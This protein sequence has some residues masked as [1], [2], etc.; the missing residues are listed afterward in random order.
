MTAMTWE[1]RR[2]ALSSDAVR[3]DVAV[4]LDASTR[5]ALAAIGVAFDQGRHAVVSR[6]GREV[7]ADAPVADLADG[8]LLTVV[9]LTA[10]SPRPSAKTV[11]MEQART[12]HHAVWWLLATTAVMLAAAALGDLA[13]S[14]T[15]LGDSTRI[16]VAAALG[17]GAAIAAAWWTLRASTTGGTGFALTATSSLAF[18]AGVVGAPHMEGATHLA[19][20]VGLLCATVL[21]ALMA[22]A[23]SER[24]VR[25]AIAAATAVF[26]VLAIVWGGTLLLQWA[27]TTAAAISLGLVAPCIRWIPNLLLDFEDGYAI[28]FENFMSSRWSVRGAVPA[29]P[30]QV[31][32][33]VVKP[34]VDESLAK[35][36]TGILMLSV[37]AAIT[38]PL[39][40]PGI[41]ASN[42]LVRIGTI[43]VIAATIAALF[44]SPRHSSSTAL[45]WMPRVTSAFMAVVVAIAFAMHSTDATRS[46]LAVML[47]VAGLLVAVLI[48]PV[49]RGASSLVWSR[50]GDTFEW[51]AVALALPMGLLAGNVLESVRTVMAG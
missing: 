51:L 12:E 44:L 9:D 22:V 19:V 33:A 34:Q 16:P 38:T 37:L 48:V 31:T 14:T 50:M 15:L 40:V 42:L 1:R 26:L 18:A 4:P 43:G 23:A 13:K 30:G 47:L 11:A 17:V 2:L 39:V 46:V 21:T 24:A 10:F 20:T 41:Y 49:G 45:R 3:F 7:D 29:D 8:T 5:D 28:Q 27:T 32:M 35:L 25:G 36:T 6:S